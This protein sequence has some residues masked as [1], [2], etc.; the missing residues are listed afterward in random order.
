MNDIKG[1]ILDRLLEI[2]ERGPINYRAGICWNVE[3]ECLS[4][5]G[6][7]IMFGCPPARNVV[8]ELFIKFPNFS[9]V[10]AYPLPGGLDKYC[11]A[12]NSN[13]LWDKSSEYGQLRWELLDF[14]IDTLQTELAQV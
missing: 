5:F 12:V 1:F 8:N 10:L 11:D 14:M 7:N 4:N 9:G 3:Y 6:G 13:T 2:R